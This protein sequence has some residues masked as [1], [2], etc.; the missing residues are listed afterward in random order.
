MTKLPFKEIRTRAQKPLYLVHTDIMGPIKPLTFP[1]KNRYVISF[2]DDFSRVAISY[3][4]AKKSLA[5]KCFCEFLKTT[6]NELGE[7]LPVRFLRCDNAPEF[8]AGEF[9]QICENESITY[10]TVNP[11][12][13]EHNS[14]A[15]RFNRKLAE[16]VRC[17][18]FD[19]G[20]PNNLWDLAVAAATYLLNRS[21]NKSLDYEL[22]IR[23]FN[24]RAKI[25]FTKIYRFGCLAYAKIL[26]D[27]ETKF[28][29]RA[30]RCAVVGY[31]RTGYILLHPNSGK[32]IRTKH[33]RCNE[34][35]VYSDFASKNDVAIVNDEELV[36][37]IKTW[38][39]ENEVGI[40]SESKSNE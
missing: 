31:Q 4:I 13:P 27:S 33:V 34:S 24:P 39:L 40:F 30:I 23:V 29:P 22:P 7:D 16:K 10:D 6:R 18:L 1:T 12:H 35:K 2:I 28:G 20:L 11:Y 5:A 3:S 17:L 25:D 19:S 32:L 8:V 26:T 15:E 38:L 21:T 37:E 14:V 9:S 36:I